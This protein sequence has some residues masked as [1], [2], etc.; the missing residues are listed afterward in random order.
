VVRLSALRTGRLYRQEIFLVLISVR[1]SVDPRTI[2]RPEGICQ[3]KIPLTISG[4]EPATFRF[5]AQCL[6]QL[7][8]WCFPC[9]SVI[10]YKYNTSVNNTTIYLYTKI[11]Y[12]V[13]A[14]SFDLIRS[15]SGRPRKQIEELF[16]F[17]CIVGSHNAMK[18]K[19][20]LNL[21]SW[22]TWG[23]PYKVEICRPDKIYYF[24]V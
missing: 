2:V 18:H 4:I 21:S 6:N 16:M 23:W 10:T 1:R 9:R 5:V 19:Q 24:C 3:W 12:F 11:V 8:I 13:R 15:S 20:L 7:Q 22:R 17:H 14:T